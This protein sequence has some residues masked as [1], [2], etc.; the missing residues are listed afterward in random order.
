MCIDM[1]LLGSVKC[2]RRCTAT[3]VATFQTDGSIK[4]VA[5][6]THYGHDNEPSMQRIHPV[7]KS[8]YY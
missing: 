7:D 2:G 1:L 3:M 5:C 4:A 8:V 6:T